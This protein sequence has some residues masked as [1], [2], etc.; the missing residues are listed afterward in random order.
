MQFHDVLDEVYISE[1]EQEAF[2]NELEIKVEIFESESPS[3]QKKIISISG[4]LKR[5][6]TDRDSGGPKIFLPKERFR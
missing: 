4:G 3:C 2:E 5:L 1:D 6:Y